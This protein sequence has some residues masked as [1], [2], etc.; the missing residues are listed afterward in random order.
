MNLFDCRIKNV[1]GHCEIYDSNR[2]FV[3]SG[4]TQD[5]AIENFKDILVEWARQS[6]LVADY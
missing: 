4:D 6:D 5:E 1:Q 2:N 3:V